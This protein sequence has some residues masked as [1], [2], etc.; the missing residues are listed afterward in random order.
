MGCWSMNETG[1]ALSNRRRICCQRWFVQDIQPAFISHEL[2][3]LPHSAKP[4]CTDFIDCCFHQV[5][6]ADLK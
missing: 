2:P 1:Y 3:T 4:Q 6:S 5:R